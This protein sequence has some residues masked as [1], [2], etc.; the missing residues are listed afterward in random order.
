MFIMKIRD[1]LTAMSGKRVAVL[2]IGVSNT[3]LIKLLLRAGA[4]VTACDKCERE[5]LGDVADELESLGAEL[6]LGEGYLHN[7]K[8]FDVIFRTPGMRPDLP[9]LLEAVEHGAVLT[10]EMEAF[11]EV[12]PC[13]IIAVTGSDGKTTTTTIIAKLLQAAGYNT[14]L[15]G[16]IGKPLLTDAIGMEAGDIAVVELSS[17]QLMT[18]KRSPSIAVVTNLAPNHL[19]VH[20][21]MSEYVAAKENIYIHQTAGDKVILNYDNDITRG[22]GEDV[23]G[24]RTWFSRKE[25]LDPGVCLRDDAIWVYGV[26]GSR[27]EV[28]PLKDILLPGQHNVEN[29]MAAIAAVDGLV[30]DNV[31]RYF[32]AEFGGVEHRIELVRELDEVRYYNDSIASSPSRTIAGLRSFDQKVILIA[33]GYDK[34]IP[35]DEFGV[36]VNKHVK[37]L[38]L[39][40]TTAEKIK[41][42][43]E[44]APEYNPENLKIT[45]L[46][47]FEETIKA[48]H[49]AAQPGD[50]VL[51]SPACASFDKFKNF[52]QRGEE[53]KRI[54]YEL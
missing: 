20:T 50:V 13:R 5:Q 47:G 27:R 9:Q 44:Q 26:D 14:Y 25:R 1:Y 30:P 52:A 8:H 19:D 38:F 17:F 36:E 51:L 42:A 32:A 2:G 4:K 35:F 11:F 21:S 41:A 18:M 6:R 39:T 45:V 31:I 43:V 53:F 7:L 49:V 54:V 34:Q 22:F 40:G 16:N 37:E 24:G 29:Y 15:G 10:S 33:G 12:C 48:A 23:P 3:P 28:L 46:D